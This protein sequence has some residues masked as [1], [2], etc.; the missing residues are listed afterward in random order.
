M[1]LLFGYYS[2]SYERENFSANMQTANQN[3]NANQICRHPLDLNY[4]QEQI[5]MFTILREMFNH[6]NSNNNDNS[7]RLSTQNQCD[8]LLSYDTIVNNDSPNSP[9]ELPSYENAIQK[10]IQNI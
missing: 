6:S 1:S 8:Q 4:R 3:L 10:H 9:D 5:I 7:M 2:Y